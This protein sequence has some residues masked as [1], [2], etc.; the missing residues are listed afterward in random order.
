VLQQVKIK[1]LACDCSS[2][3]SVLPW[4]LERGWFETGAHKRYV[5]ARERRMEKEASVI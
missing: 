4:T 1:D 3:S 5:G 2:L